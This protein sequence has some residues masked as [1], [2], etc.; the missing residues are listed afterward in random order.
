MCQILVNG[1][2]SYDVRVKIIYF[3]KNVMKANC[4]KKI[5]EIKLNDCTI[6]DVNKFKKE[7]NENG[8]EDKSGIFI[9]KINFVMLLSLNYFN[10]YS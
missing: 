6:L 8:P 3:S 7:N 4:I 9:G 2:L 10:L 1:I 5:F